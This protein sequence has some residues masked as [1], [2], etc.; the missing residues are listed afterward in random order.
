MMEQ[1]FSGR[2]PSSG[3]TD[4]PQIGANSVIARGPIAKRAE[5]GDEMHVLI[6]PDSCT[7]PTF[8]EKE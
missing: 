6:A 2:A 4:R 1:M 7:A 3:R 5:A 8:K